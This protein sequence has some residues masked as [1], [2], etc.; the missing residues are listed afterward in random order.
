MVPP[1]LPFRRNIPRW[2]TL[3]IIG[4]SLHNSIHA[5]DEKVSAVSP[6]EE[7]GDTRFQDSFVTSTD[8]H[9]SS[10]PKNQGG[11]L[12]KSNTLNHNNTYED[13]QL[14]PQLVWPW[15]HNDTN[16]ACRARENC[17]SCTEA[18]MSCHWCSKDNECHAKGSWY[19]CA[20]GDSCT[21]PSNDTKDNH[22]RSH[23]SCT[24]CA[25]SSS[26]CHW[27]AF[28]DLCHAIGSMY[29][30]GSGVNC[31]SNDRCKRTEPG[32]IQETFFKDVGVIPLVLIVAST[33]GVLCCSTV[34][35]T[36]VSALKGAYDNFADVRSSPSSETDGHRQ[37]DAQQLD[38]IQEEDA[39]P[40]EDVIPEEDEAVEEEI[41]D[42]NDGTTRTAEDCE[43]GNQRSKQSDDGSP[44]EER[45][46]DGH[47]PHDA[48]QHTNET[49]LTQP[50]LPVTAHPHPTRLP[51][52]HSTPRS[53]PHMTCLMHSCRI[54]YFLTVV[55]AIVMAGASIVFFPKLPVY[56]VCSDEI[57]WKSII[58]GLES[59]KMQASF[60]IL[61]SVENKNYLDIA[62]ENIAGKIKY[63]GDDVGTF[64]MKRTIIQH[65]SITDAL[66][67]C[68]VAP[69]KWDTLGMISDYYKGTLMIFVDANGSVKVRGFQFTFP[70][71]ITDYAVKVNDQDSKDRHL[72]A[73]PDWKDVT[74]NVSPALP[75][76]A[77]VV[78]QVHFTI[79]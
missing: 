6:A 66:L 57:A 11:S 2:I 47:Q 74:P 45:Q 5:L 20:I 77:A 49:T 22:C 15:N 42:G 19:G 72:C 1:S 16:N 40:G 23:G 67:T 32:V 51:P 69:G 53:S 4:L 3:A 17:T 61:I 73:C 30:C 64:S 34:L 28:D 35:F 50:L 41:S 62:L 79:S 27:C 38:V 10:G 59:M 7:Y 70:I 31:Y 75:F 25:V 9:D 71:K 13:L 37:Y 44:E 52:N 18:S 26:L 68:T 65:S 14:D 56:N 78:D 29:G 46:S 36:V 76:Q 60:E 58:A 8:K 63:N 54:W 39:I 55:G 12:R 48:Q 21:S 24:E 33:M 43:E